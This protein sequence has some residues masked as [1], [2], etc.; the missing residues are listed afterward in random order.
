MATEHEAAGALS[1]AG[2]G[3]QNQVPDVTQGP[4]NGR[5]VRQT[6]RAA[7]QRTLLAWRSP[8]SRTSFHGVPSTAMIR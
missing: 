5:D 1:N 8:A 3:A 2:R 4:Q 7:Q 6:R